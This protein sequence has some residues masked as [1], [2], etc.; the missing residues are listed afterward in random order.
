MRVNRF[1]EGGGQSIK[2][3]RIPPHD[4]R[5]M[6]FTSSDSASVLRFVDVY[7]TLA[8]AIDSN[9]QLVGREL[10]ECRGRV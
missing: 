1:A 10:A 5:N 9:L 8:I 7:S 3:N 4:P 2:I 6:M